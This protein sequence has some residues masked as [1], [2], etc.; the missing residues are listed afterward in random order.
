MDAEI[1]AALL[2]LPDGVI[3]A[4]YRHYPGFHYFGHALSEEERTGGVAATL[5][6]YTERR[7]APYET[8]RAAA[9]RDALRAAIG[10]A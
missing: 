1:K 10:A 7:L 4:L 6:E 9:V 8:Q 5:I 2:A 3:V